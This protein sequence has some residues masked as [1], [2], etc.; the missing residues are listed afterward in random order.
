MTFNRKS[1][2]GK[3]LGL[4]DNDPGSADICRSA[5]TAP[6]NKQ[7]QVTDKSGKEI[8]WPFSP[9]TPGEMLNPK[10]IGKT[11]RVLGTSPRASGQNQ[12]MNNGLVG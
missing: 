6:I 1:S 3:S 4:Y 10:Q 11:P 8:N 2:L 12:A 5:G 9:A 7:G